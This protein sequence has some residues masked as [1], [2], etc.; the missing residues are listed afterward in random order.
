MT[1]PE[2]GATSCNTA[3]E[4]LAWCA[5]VSSAATQEDHLTGPRLLR[6]LIR[7]GEWSPL[8]QVSV[9]FEVHTSRRISRQI[10]RHWTVKP[11]E[12]SQRWA[13]PELNPYV[14]AARHPVA[15]NRAVSALTLNTVVNEAWLRRQHTVWKAAKAAYLWAMDNGMH[16]EVAAVVL[17]EGMTPTRLMLHATVRTWLH[18][19][20]L[21]L[22][23]NTQLEHRMVAE[24]IWA[25]I[26][27]KFPELES[28]VELANG[29]P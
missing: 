15:G 17:P 13:E 5:R 26:A 24:H 22:R 2:P 18:Y 28:A 16:H 27:L 25:A 19:S 1:Q 9:N 21:R 29:Q 14:T 20:Q 4:L 23:P 3:E 6:R 11:Q 10:I 8:D 7:D 12:F